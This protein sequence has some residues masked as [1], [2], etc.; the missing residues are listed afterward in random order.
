MLDAGSEVQI[1]YYFSIILGSLSPHFPQELSCFLTGILCGLLIPSKWILG[2]HY[3]LF[4][5][6][7]T[8]SFEILAHG[9][10][11]SLDHKTADVL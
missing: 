5:Q 4:W 8:D 6:R 3:E 10:S 7:F 11:S 9:F 1:L 2:Q